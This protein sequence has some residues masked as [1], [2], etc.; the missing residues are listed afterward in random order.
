MV[1]GKMYS[2]RQLGWSRPCDGCFL[3]RQLLFFLRLLSPQ[4]QMG[5]FLFLRKKERKYELES[6]G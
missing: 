4:H 2:V 5:N 6:V 1:V 3:D